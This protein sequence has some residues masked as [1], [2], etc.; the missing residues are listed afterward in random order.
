[1][2]DFLC[3]PFGIPLSDD[4]LFIPFDILLSDDSLC[5]PFSIPLSD[6]F[7]CISFGIPLSGDFLWI[8][9]GISLSGDFS[10]IPF[11]I[12]LPDG[13]LCFPFSILLFDD[14]LCTPF[15]SALYHDFL[16]IMFSIPEVVLSRRILSLHPPDK[17]V[18]IL[19]GWCEKWR[20][21]LSYKIH[22]TDGCYCEISFCNKLFISPFISL[23]GVRSTAESVQLMTRSCSV[24]HFPFSFYRN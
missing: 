8:S 19:C 1:M 3:I 24:L 20:L 11:S 4:F 14:F 17:I 12:P 18:N 5:I 2:S 6:D 13:L 10:F 7:L 21:S 16:Y 22:S 23:Q 15:C 9:F